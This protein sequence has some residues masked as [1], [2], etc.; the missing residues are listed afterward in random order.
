MTKISLYPSITLPVRGTDLADIS[1]DLGSGSYVSKRVLLSDL[2]PNL[3]KLVGS[4]DNTTSGLTADNVQGAIDEV[5]ETTLYRANG[6]LNSNRTVTQAGNRLTFS[7]GFIGLG[8]YTATSKVT[9]RGDTTDGTQAGLRVEDSASAPKFLVMNDG[10]VSVGG[11]LVSNNQL[12]VRGIGTT[13][14]T[15]AM[16]IDNSA[17][18]NILD[19]K[20]NRQVRI[21]N[22][23]VSA[24]LSVGDGGNAFSAI[25]NGTATYT[26]GAYNTSVSG[27]SLFISS[28]GTG[29]DAV[30]GNQRFRGAAPVVFGAN[31]LQA[32]PQVYIT[33]SDSGRTY[34]LQA[35]GQVNILDALW[36][37][38]NGTNDPSAILEIN[39]PTRGFRIPRLLAINASVI[40]PVDGL[41]LYVTTTNATFTSIGFW[42][43]ENGA[44]VKL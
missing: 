7:G 1:E 22:T 19:V 11:V 8:G 40:A 24:S 20:D 2:A 12:N 29:L 14:A 9:V 6:S 16:R 38:G 32:N 3:I 13:T 43:Y 23:G 42:G 44:W 36:I 30:N 39:S 25:F 27:T 28:S 31:G 10:R 34:S 18:V 37:G 33:N 41:M 17:G 26:I 35:Q 4:Y 5:R 15:T 21:N